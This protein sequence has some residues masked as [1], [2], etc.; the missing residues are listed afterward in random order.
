MGLPVLGGL[1]VT[2]LLLAA[3]ATPLDRGEELYRQGDLRGALEVWSDAEYD[4]RIEKRI[5]EVNEQF[6][7]R[8]RRYEKRAVFYEEQE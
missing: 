6:D 8:L 5:N 1:I 4:P 3:C 2:S 7:R